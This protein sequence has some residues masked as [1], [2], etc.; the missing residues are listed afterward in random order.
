MPVAVSIDWWGVVITRDGT[1]LDQAALQKLCD[2]TNLAP[3]EET[4][5]DVLLHDAW[6]VVQSPLGCD[7]LLQAQM[8]QTFAFLNGVGGMSADREYYITGLVR[9][10][11][12]RRDLAALRASGTPHRET[13][14][15]IRCAQTLRMRWET[16]L[17]V[18]TMLL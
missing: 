17:E 9:K 4:E 15:A 14:R 3:W 10:L 5:D 7:A 12:M 16:F 6:R 18:L 2:A 13:A 11:T 8:R 1:H